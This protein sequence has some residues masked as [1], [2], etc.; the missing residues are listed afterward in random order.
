MRVATA[1]RQHSSQIDDFSP[2]ASKTAQIRMKFVENF[3]ERRDKFS[4]FMLFFTQQTKNFAGMRIGRGSSSAGNFASL[5]CISQSSLTKFAVRSDA[6][7][8]ENLENFHAVCENFCDI[9]LECARLSAPRAT[10]TRS[11]SCVSCNL[12]FTCLRSGRTRPKFAV[13]A[14]KFWNFAKFRGVFALF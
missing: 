8:Q 9:R 10:T 14:E 7:S 12:R 3:A 4:N 11:S 5:I 6:R 13:R 2:R 1:Q